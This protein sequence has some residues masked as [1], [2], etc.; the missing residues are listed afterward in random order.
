MI[1]PVLWRLAVVLT[2]LMGSPLAHA[3]LGPTE[4]PLPP[5][6]ATLDAYLHLSLNSI[7]NSGAAL[8]NDFKNPDPEKCYQHYRQSLEAL[9]PVLSHHPDLQAAIR[10]AL[11]DVEKDPEWRIRMAGKYL[12]TPRLQPLVRQKGFAL[13]AFLRELQAKLRDY[14]NKPE[15]KKPLT[16]KT[17]SKIPEKPEALTVPPAEILQGKEI[18]KPK[19][20][21]KKPIEASPA[22]PPE[23]KPVETS[24]T[25]PSDK[26]SIE[27]KEEKKPDA[28]APS[29]KGPG[30]AAQ[31]VLR[32]TVTGNV[33][34]QKQP[35]TYGSVVMT[36]NEED[37][38]F[39]G[40]IQKDGS[41]VIDNIPAGRYW[42]TV[43]LATL[44]PPKDV[45]PVVLPEVYTDTK[46]TPLLWKFEGGQEK[47]PIYLL[48]PN[49]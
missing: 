42:V 43:T 28:V 13:N 32:G 11:E 24:P 40:L 21:D 16:E 6:S 12:T 25:M 9:L 18:V 7:I 47:M 34:F 1:F 31:P 5:D 49:P 33:F 38:A 26:K 39:M 15:D 17:T 10:R 37:K 45:K 22:V 19:A 20:D 2:C 3:A 14:A 8:Y 44:F 4:P 36:L 30:A 27:K 46:K 48:T 29:D 35:L 23:K 41:F